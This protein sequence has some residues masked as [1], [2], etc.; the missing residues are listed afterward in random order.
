MCVQ[1]LKTG[2]PE[3][4]G[5]VKLIR[6]YNQTGMKSKLRPHDRIL[7]RPSLPDINASNLDS[8]T[9][10]QS[11]GPGASSVGLGEG[12]KRD[13]PALSVYKKSPSLLGSRGARSGSS[14]FT[15]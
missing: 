14:L 3:V 4:F 13:A 7:R 6:S 12:A 5:D 11:V 15:G 8:L 9:H 10:A 1:K 2:K